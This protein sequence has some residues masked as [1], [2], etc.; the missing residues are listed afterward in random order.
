MKGQWVPGHSPYGA[1]PPASTMMQQRAQKEPWEMND[2]FLNVKYL[3]VC[4]CVCGANVCLIAKYVLLS[5]AGVSAFVHNLCVCVQSILKYRRPASLQDSRGWKRIYNPNTQHQK[6]TKSGAKGQCKRG[7]G[8]DEH[9]VGMTTR[10]PDDE[11]VKPQ[12]RLC[13]PI[14]DWWRL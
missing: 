8:M 3:H 1:I 4:V 2:C 13:W 12:T 11:R 14:P 9:D 6:G 7:V 10:W 5:R